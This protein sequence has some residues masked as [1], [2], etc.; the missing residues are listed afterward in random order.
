MCAFAVS[1]ALQAL[2]EDAGAK[3]QELQAASEQA[4]ARHRQQVQQV[5]AVVAAALA[6]GDV[7]VLLNANLPGI[8]GAAGT[9]AAAAAAGRGGVSVMGTPV[10]AGAGGVGGTP[11]VVGLA[12]ALAAAAG[13]GTPGA[14]QGKSVVEVWAMYQDMV[15]AARGATAPLLVHVV[16]LMGT[17]GGPA[18]RA[19]GLVAPGH[20]G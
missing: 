4:A 1:Q 16:G 19:K 9:P 20:G 11:G 14:F 13:E 6:A 12:A 18:R 17:A 8:G 3:L 2:G 15:G 5:T 10:G 7:T